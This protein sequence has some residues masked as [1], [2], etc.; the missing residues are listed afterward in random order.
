MQ[1]LP[2]NA[3]SPIPSDAAA[4][5]PFA[6]PWREAPRTTLLAALAL[7]LYLSPLLLLGRDARFLIFDNLDHHP[8]HMKALIESGTLFAP[9]SAIVP[10]MMNGLPRGAFAT[11]L[12]YVPILY[13]LLGP[14]GA[15]A[16]NQLLKRLVA[17][18]GLWLLLRS[19][20]VRDAT[21]APLAVGAALCFALLPFPPAYAMNMELLPLLSWALLEIRA[22]RGGWAAWAIVVASPFCASL[23]VSLMFLLLVAGA[24]WLFDAIRTRR[25]NWRLALAAAVIGALSLLVEHRLVETSIVAKSFEPHR[26]ERAMSFESVSFGEAVY[27]SAINA[28]KGH[29]TTPSLQRWFVGAAVAMA[30]GI[31]LWRRKPCW[32]LLATLAACGAI[33]VWLGFW[34]WEG[35][36]PL[37][38]RVELLRTFNW[39][40]FHYLHPMLWH[41]AFAQSLLLAWRELPRPWRTALP[42]A[43]LAL[44]VGY[45]VWSSDELAERRAGNP[46][47]RAFYSPE[48]FE[49]I[50]DFIGRDQ[51]T[52]R[53]ASLG[54]ETALP[55]FSGFHTLDSYQYLYPLEWKRKFEAIIARELAKDPAM[56]EWFSQ[57]RCYVL[58]NEV[59]TKLPREKWFLVDKSLDFEVADLG[60]DAEAFKA[61]G[62][63]YLLSAARIGN[64][65]ALGLDLL[66]TFERADSPWRV[67]LYRAR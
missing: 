51:A 66:K 13:W 15:L 11:D 6:A 59:R 30:L 55:Q 20:V 1:Q 50:R 21:E 31:M 3:I 4:P 64:A 67:R 12:S 48:L 2:E 41:V 52:Y 22:R 33:S 38:E 42:S 45:C 61:L 39:S 16:T 27:R 24:A 58:S 5:A 34:K 18:F 10:N 32:P 49:E 9:A 47:F 35:W 8:A 14:F 53:V 62:G 28:V 19:R 23:I 56:E 17:F 7:A 54:I 46:G 26:A 29:R 25:P 36:L 57:N 44:Q 60:F 43:L 65:D 40:R 37:K 63:E